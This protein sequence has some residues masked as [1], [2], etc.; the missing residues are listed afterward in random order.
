MK[1]MIMTNVNKNDDRYK[2]KLELDRIAY[3][4]C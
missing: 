3:N 1:N 2:K 4:K